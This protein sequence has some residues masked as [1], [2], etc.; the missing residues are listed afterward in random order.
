[1]SPLDRF[2]ERLRS[3]EGRKKGVSVVW[4]GAPLV[5]MRRPDSTV[6]LTPKTDVIYLPGPEGDD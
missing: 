5:F 1:M 6:V 4:P 2:V 3:G